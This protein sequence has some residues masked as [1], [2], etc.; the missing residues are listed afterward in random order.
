MNDVTDHSMR[1]PMRLIPMLSAAVLCLS[2]SATA[3]AD[4]T[5]SGP[6]V[7]ERVSPFSVVV[8]NGKRVGRR[9]GT[10]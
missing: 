6:Q 5:I 7:D 1:F 2:M 8:S 9:R 4:S 10:S 3:R